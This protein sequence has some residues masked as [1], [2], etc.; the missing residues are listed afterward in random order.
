MVLI[1]FHRFPH[2]LH[3]TNV[4]I[5]SSELRVWSCKQ[6]ILQHLLKVTCTIIEASTV[7]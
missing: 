6:N 1:T 7:L 4:V 2:S 3:K 5:G